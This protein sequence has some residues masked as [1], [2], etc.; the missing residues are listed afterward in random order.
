MDNL[1][2]SNIEGEY[3][4][5][6]LIYLGEKIKDFNPTDEEREFILAKLKFENGKISIGGWLFLPVIGLVMSIIVLFIQMGLALESYSI[7][8]IVIGMVLLI[9]SVVVLYNCIKKRKITISLLKALCI[10]NLISSLFVG[11]F[12]NSIGNLIWLI[13][14]FKS[15]RVKYTFVED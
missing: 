6:I 7:I 1:S 12:A 8:G 4:E 2:Q 15:V 14:F 9:L 3:K 5:S 13:Y 10:I 11:E